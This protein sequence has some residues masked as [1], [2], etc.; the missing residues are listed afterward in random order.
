[1]AR[2]ATLPGLLDRLRSVVRS[3]TSRS[4][5]PLYQAVG[6]FYEYRSVL[7]RR[8]IH[9]RQGRA[10]DGRWAHVYEWAHVGRGGKAGPYRSL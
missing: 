5:A 2:L 6:G 10:P 3:T 9:V 1:M 4:D 7:G 8:T